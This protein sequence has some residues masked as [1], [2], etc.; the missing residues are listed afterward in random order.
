MFGRT[1]QTTIPTQ[2]KRLWSSSCNRERSLRVFRSLVRGIR[3]PYIGF[4]YQQS[5]GRAGPPV[6]V[7]C[8]PHLALNIHRV[9]EGLE[10]NVPPAAA[11]QI[12]YRSDGDSAEIADDLR[13]F[14]GA[15]SVLDERAIYSFLQYGA[16]IPPLSMWKGVYR[17]VPGR[18]TVFEKFPRLMV[19]ERQDDH[20]ATGQVEK[21]GIGSSL[22]A[23]VSS[24]LQVIDKSLLA[25]REKHRLIILFSGGVDSG[26][27]AARAAALGLKDTVLVNYS[28][29]PDDSESKLA[30]EMALHLGLNFQRMEDVVSGSDVEDVLSHAASYYRSP[31]GD[32]S[33]IPTC[34]LVR[35]LIQ[36]FGAEYIALDGT[37]ADGAFGLF[38]KA[39]QWQ[40]LCSLPLAVRQLGSLAYRISG[41]WQRQSTV[42]Y[43]LRLLRRAAQHRHPLAA[44][45]ENCLEGIAYS[46]SKEIREEVDGLAISWLDSLCPLEPDLQLPAIDLALVCACI[47]AQKSR[48]L[49]AASE[50]DVVYPYLSE[51][52]FQL[53]LASGNWEGAAG[54]PKWL[55]KAAL[56]RQVPQEMVYRRKCGFVAPVAQKFSQPAF[57]AAF[58][59]LVTGASPISPFLHED[60]FRTLQ[61]KIRAGEA[62]PSQT[63]YFIWAAV[64]VSEWLQQVSGTGTGVAARA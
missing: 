60:F 34:A 1:S 59:K 41:A 17:A 57:L 39:R 3:G 31:F 42:E 58:E 13:H 8:S 55:L 43:R 18:T 52:M 51:E 20:R 50:L 27:L 38:A 45:A 14:A 12:Y 44:V 19:R 16:V 25:T 61:P 64:F 15:A 48:S 28:F 32:H 23:Q 35:N 56:A 22:D 6:N 47:F 5:I 26:L 36:R 9:P 33:A 40:R 62:L 7:S 10:V 4:V 11:D 2:Y 49:F 54:E 46:A 21:P 53:A 24:V 29:G 37:G 30:E 63:A